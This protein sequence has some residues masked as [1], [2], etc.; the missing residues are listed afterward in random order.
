MLANKPAPQAHTQ[1]FALESELAN[2]RHITACATAGMQQPWSRDQQQH[3]AANSSL[4]HC[5][6]HRRAGKQEFTDTCRTQQAHTWPYNGGLQAAAS[7]ASTH[8][9]ACSEQ[10]LSTAQHIRCLLHSMQ[11]LYTALKA[12]KHC[13]NS[14]GVQPM[15]PSTAQQQVDTSSMSTAQQLRTGSN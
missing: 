13:C 4:Q 9:L 8:V 5:L 10:H 3:S 6:F 15:W 2:D 1:Q 11:L 12:I 14:S 7:Q